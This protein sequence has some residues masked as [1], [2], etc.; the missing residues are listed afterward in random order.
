MFLP[1]GLT[2]SIT[3]KSCSP[4][5]EMHSRVIWITF[6]SIGFFFYSLDL[7]TQLTSK[8]SPPLP[9]TPCPTSLVVCGLW[10]DWGHQQKY[11]GYLALSR[12]IL[13]MIFKCFSSIVKMMGRFWKVVE[14]IKACGISWYIS[15][16]SYG[17]RCKQGAN[18][19]FEICYFSFIFPKLCLLVFNAFLWWHVC[20]TKFLWK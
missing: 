8:F 6:Q 5:S 4:L 3:C 7:R 19:N 11:Q 13:D 16:S 2:I 9:G 15:W 14:E 12:D 1:H 20:T 17:D 10:L 18:F